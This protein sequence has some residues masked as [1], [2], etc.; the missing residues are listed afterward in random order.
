MK[1]KTLV[2]IIFCALVLFASRN[3]I[4]EEIFPFFFGEDSDFS[5]NELI[6]LGVLDKE[7][8]LE[9]FAN[10]AD[11]DNRFSMS[12]IDISSLDLSTLSDE[13]LGMLMRVIAKDMT[14]T[15]L[16]K[17]GEFTLQDLKDVGLFDIMIDSLNN[18]NE[19]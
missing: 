9:S 14:M 3:F 2:I 7:N 16:I 10:F 5:L 17:S 13:Q 18:K 6:D 15:E 1:T 19:E 12:D 8:T 4:K 11:N